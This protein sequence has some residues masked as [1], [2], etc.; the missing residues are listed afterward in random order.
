MHINKL[1][2]VIFS[3]TMLIVNALTFS[4]C[5]Q[6]K[7]ITKDPLL[8]KDIYIYT[9]Q[10]D[11]GMIVKITNYRGIVMNITVPDKNQQP[12]DVILAYN[13]IQKYFTDNNF[14]GAIIG[15]YAN[16]IAN[17][18]FCLNCKLY[19]L[20]KNDCCNS[21]HSGPV[22]FNSAVWNSKAR[23][24]GNNRIELVLTYLSPSVK[25]NKVESQGF[26]GNLF[27]T[28]IYSLSNK[29]NELSIDYCAI[30]DEDTFINLTNHSYFN[31]NGEGNGT[32]LNHEL[33]I[34][35]DKITLTNCQ[36]IP[37]GK[38]GYVK[39]TPFDFKK[40]KKIGVGIYDT[41]NCQIAFAHGYDQN[42]VL[43]RCPCSN[44]PLL[45]A[46]VRSPRTGIQLNIFTTEP[47]LQFYS[48]NSLNKTIIGKK[49]HVYDAHTGFALEA[50]HFPDSPNHKNF[51][52]T[53]LKKGEKYHQITIM[54]F[55][56]K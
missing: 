7:F 12:T 18:E 39:G 19:E 14:F 50:Q 56:L 43:N 29:D 15:R 8:K 32:I 52:S 6:K 1:F 17:G 51:P 40:F 48:G 44:E 30:S 10:N 16:R 54:K 36:Q 45:A 23:K 27:T 22:G 49:G 47:G 55:G 21:L 13:S 5:V 34:N 31:L 4:L 38:C 28:V 41:N 11:L 20:P 3:F 46:K 9:M 53:L 24:I 25:K 2:L 26:P 33:Y 42:F 37:T 35:A